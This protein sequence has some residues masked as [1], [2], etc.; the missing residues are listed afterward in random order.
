[1]RR[2]AL[3]IFVSAVLLSTG[4]HAAT[5]RAGAATSNVT[6]PLGTSINGY[7]TD[8][9]ATHIHDEL[10]ARCL[11]LDDGTTRIAFVVLDSCLIQREIFDQAKQLIHE[12]TGLPTNQIL[13][14]S[15]HTHS[16]AASASIFQS[17]A[18]SEYIK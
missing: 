18:D 4:A 16:A 11:V 14:S 12:Q 6:P 2:A 3:A 1:M 8:R 5:F 10:H 15:T 9:K 13:I 7:M 17:D